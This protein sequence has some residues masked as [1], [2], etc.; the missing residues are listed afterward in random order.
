M[1]K[2]HVDPLKAVRRQARYC[3]TCGMS[4]PLLR[5]IVYVAMGE[6]IVMG[7][8]I[9]AWVVFMSGLP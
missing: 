6:G 4:R 3:P 5:L 1:S 2:P 9:V 8:L 7:V